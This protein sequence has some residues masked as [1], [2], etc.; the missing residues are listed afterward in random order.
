MAASIEAAGSFRRS[1]SNPTTSYGN[2]A[3]KKNRGGE[4]V[5]YLLSH[6]F[7]GISEY[8]ENR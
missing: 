4:G 7:A 3:A 5:N 8:F 2:P 6:L 1:K